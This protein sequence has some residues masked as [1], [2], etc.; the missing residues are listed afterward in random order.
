MQHL[1]TKD[2]AGLHQHHQF[3]EAT[4]TLTNIQ[5]ECVMLALHFHLLDD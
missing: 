5:V 2:M 4:Q 3:L 1:S